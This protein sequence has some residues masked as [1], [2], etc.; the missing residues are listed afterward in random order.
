MAFDIVVCRDENREHGRERN[1]Y[2]SAADEGLSTNIK[3]IGGTGTAGDPVRVVLTVKNICG[4]AFRGIIQVRYI[5]AKRGARFFMPAFMYG[6]NRGEC[7]QR[8]ENRYPR[9]RQG[10]PEPPSSSWWMV[11][12]DRLSHPALFAYDGEKIYGISAAPYICTNEKRTFCGYSCSIDEGSIGWTIGYENAPE[13]YVSSHDIYEREFVPFEI[14]AG[15]SVSAEICLYEYCA[16]AETGVNAAIK[17]V[18]YRYHEM[19]RKGADIKEAS[20]ELS[21]AVADFAWLDDD[22]M[23]SGFVFD[24]ENGYR[25]NKLGSLSWTNGMSVAYPMLLAASLFNDERK[26]EQALCFIN[27]AVKNS[28]N[29]NSGLLYDAVNDGKWSAKGW[30][31]DGMY[32]KGHSSYVV[33]Q[34][35]YYII[36]SY[37][38]ERDEFGTIHS[39]WIELASEVIDV[40]EKSRNGDW[41]YPYILSEETGAGLEY[42]SMAGAWCLAAVSAYMAY[43]G[44]MRYLHDAEKSEMHYYNKYVKKMECT[45]GPLDVS[46]APDNESI[47]AYIRSVR[48]LYT[49][50]EK[51]IYIE[52]MYDALCY[53]FSFKFCYN[54][55]VSVP[56]LSSVGWSSCGGS[57][58]S[59]ANPH[60]HPMSSSITDEMLWYYRKTGDRYVYDRLCDTIG[61]GC[62]TYNRYDREYGYGK[63]GWMSERFCYSQGLLTERYPDGSP[64]S[65]W[66]ALMPWA[67][68]SIIEGL[69]G[70]CRDF[71]YDRELAE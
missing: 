42:D 24:D 59:V 13:F 23:Y 3:Q 27:S 9:L 48:L 26:R 37:I 40:L 62:Q 18:Y 63:K 11:R 50:T 57:V 58:T 29:K 33:G 67:S 49:I 53:E 52:H 35:V 19:P 10:D 65:T 15:E 1:R 41:E 8:V 14:G 30:W 7:P 21:D 68:C 71:T 69:S 4:A 64:A 32:T 44:D 2:I 22:G 16:P 6:H 56:P 31:F 25:Y 39:D 46:K 36:K 20:K 54:S 34:A 43:T 12:G 66:F 70:D 17:D 55:P 45:G 61:W 38:I 60:I 5:F 28:L 47:L 51:D